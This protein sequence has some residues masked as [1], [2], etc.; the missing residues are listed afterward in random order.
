MP[1]PDSLFVV[2]QGLQALLLS[3]PAMRWVFLKKLV[4]GKV[5]KGWEQK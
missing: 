2:R 1:P 4:L 3:K 5:G